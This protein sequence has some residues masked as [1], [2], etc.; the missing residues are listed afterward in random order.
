MASRKPKVVVTRKLPDPVEARMRELFD[1]ELNADDR[2]MSRARLA[3]AMARA[4]ALVPT[5]TDRID[6]ELVAAAGPQLR[7][8]AS[9]GA[10]VDHIDLAA[11]AARG[12]TVTNTPSVLADDT[13]DAVMG[14]ILAVSRRLVEGAEVVQAGG[15]HGWAPTWMLGHR[16][17][18]K[19]LGIIGLGRIGLAVA[20]RARAFGLSIHYH[21]RKPVPAIV[22]EPMCGSSTTLGRR[23]RAGSIA[24]S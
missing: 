6:A 17:G 19:K 22:A 18:G 14:L 10:G 24:G 8:I 5:V 20:R 1:V 11:A 21:N 16:I 4:D 2:P 7:L 13:A 9:F 3:E 15:F 12:V 23:S